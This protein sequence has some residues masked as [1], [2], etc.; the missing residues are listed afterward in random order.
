[1]DG[2]DVFPPEAGPGHRGRHALPTQSASINDLETS[3]RRAILKHPRRQTSL[4][5]LQ[6]P[7]RY[8]LLTFDVEEFDLPRE[9]GQSLAEEKMYSIS[10]AGLRTIIRLL[11]EVG[12]VRAT[13]FTTA[14]FARKFP[15]LV[16]QVAR[17]GHEV[18]LHGY[19]HWD[20]YARMSPGRSL[21]RLRRA[22][23]R[24][25]KIVGRKVSGFRAP[26]N[27]GPGPDV[28]RRA[29]L[30]YDSSLHPTCIPGRY[31]H[32]FESRRLHR[33]GSLWEVPISVT[34]LLRLPFTWLF[35]RNLPSAY[36]RAC[37]LASAPGTGYINIYF[38]PWEFVDLGRIPGVP[39]Y[40]TR[41][42]GR[43]LTRKLKNYLA[44][45]KRRGF[46]SLPMG[47]FIRRAGSAGVRRGGEA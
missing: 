34:P 9:F 12:G 38:H 14:D 44:W 20:N 32:L 41:N 36:A 28:L 8:F 29:G 22:R 31:N 25:E 18:G 5:A 26:R 39:G 47:E 16:R 24:I 37:S 4:P 33:N 40:L 1:M 23:Q 46:Q 35:F 45:V 10:A 17:R 11:A 15:G 21:A 2:R 19:S 42:T 7:R 6:P 27:L 3:I 43:P 13:F 30:G